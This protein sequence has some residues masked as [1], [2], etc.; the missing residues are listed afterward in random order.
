MLLTRHRTR[1]RRWRR[2][3]PFWG[4]LVTVLAGAE[5]CALPLAPLKVML[6]QGV[7]GVPSVLMGLVMV[8]LGVSVWFA[9]HYRTLA[10]IVTTLIAAFALV[11]S[12]LGGFLAG[13]LLGI[14][15]GGLMFAWQPGAPSPGTPPEEATESDAAGRSASSAPHDTPSHAP[16]SD[17]QGAQ[18]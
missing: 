3:R 8:V 4:G 1:F 17:P 7:A 13:T 16:L 12:N 15:G 2:S 6:A 10:G 5:I 18:P 9:P 11:L 14:L